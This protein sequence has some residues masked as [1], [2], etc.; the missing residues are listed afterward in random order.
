MTDTDVLPI[1]DLE[2]EGRANRTW[3]WVAIALVLGLGV[4]ALLVRVAGGNDQSPEER[5]AAIPG[6]L[7]DADSFAYELKSTTATGGMSLDLDL[8]GTVD[9]ANKRGQATM[10]LLGKKLE[11][12]TDGDTAYLK[13]PAEARGMS[14]GKTWLR[15][16]SSGF[17]PGAGLTTS[18]PLSTLRGLA[19][20]GATI[21]EVGTEDVRGTETTHYRTHLDLTKN[22]PAEATQG[23]PAG[24]FDQL[25]N[26]PVD[27]WLDHDNRPRRYSFTLDLSA[28]GRQ[29]STKVTMET[30]DYGKP[31][32]VEA[33]DP[34]DVADGD[35][36]GLGALFGG[37]S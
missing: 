21:D 18:D 26:V 17:V 12:V 22:L 14:Q 9:V 29:A 13:V 7:N 15:L 28:E 3:L 36:S 10:E 27:V 24:L 30:F 5:F 1:A 11:L 16:P 6:A 35:A 19:S 23:G 34:A 20:P 31:V 4:A 37:G 32:H 8:N 25:K 33:P 2:P